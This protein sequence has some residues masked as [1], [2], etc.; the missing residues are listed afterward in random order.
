VCVRMDILDPLLLKVLRLLRKDEEE[1]IR[2]QICC[3]GCHNKKMAHKP[4]FEGR[5][6]KPKGVHVCF[7]YGGFVFDENKIN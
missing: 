6:M 2:K 5:H 3:D 7:D 1:K 4:R